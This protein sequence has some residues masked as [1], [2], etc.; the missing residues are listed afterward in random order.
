M[1]E[2]GLEIDGFL[3]SSGWD[4]AVR[5]PLASDASARRYQRLN[6]AARS[7]ILMDAPPSEMSITPF[8][9]IARH[10]RELGF[11]TPEVYLEDE[12]LGLALI[13]DFGDTTY[14]NI[15]LSKPMCEHEL[16]G[17]AV[18]VLSTLHGL[19]NDQVLLPQ[20]ADYSEEILLEE[21]SRFV[22][23][24]IPAISG[25]SL[26][27]D[28]AEEFMSLWRTVLRTFLEQPATLVLRD[29]HIDNLILL[30]RRTAVQ[31]CGLLDF[32]D[33]VIGAGAYDLMSLLEDARR[34]IDPALAEKMRARYF[35]QMALSPMEQDHFNTAYAI[36]A[37]QRHTKVIGLFVR[38][39][40]QHGKPDYLVHLP[41]V[42]RL[43]ERSLCHPAL[44]VLKTWFDTNVPEN[45]RGIPPHLADDNI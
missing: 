11:S 1:P 29:F 27:A 40:E 20:I 13:E 45:K 34:D 43:L 23:W 25:A 7:A 41:R 10:L 35:R 3:R 16:Y 22:R 17:L 37:A 42:W 39:C 36:A 14:R 12:A 30:E 4:N 38:L 18:D 8:V 44:I 6:D 21:V 26:S 33:A 15:L 24:Y 32:Q 9:R 2:R 5:T 19:P 31:R 28:K